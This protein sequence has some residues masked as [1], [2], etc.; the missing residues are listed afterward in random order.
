MT[1][2]QQTEVPAENQKD[3][4]TAATGALKVRN[5]NAWSIHPMFREYARSKTPIPPL[6]SDP[7]IGVPGTRVGLGVGLGAGCTGG[8]PWQALTVEQKQKLERQSLYKN[9]RNL[10]LA[11]RPQLIMGWLIVRPPLSFPNI[12][13]VICNVNNFSIRTASSTTYPS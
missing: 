11:P 13:C 4:P 12:P 8:V 7:A 6:S 3:K 1:R 9:R 5:T 2:K 10:T